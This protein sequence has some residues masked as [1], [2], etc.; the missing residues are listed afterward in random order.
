MQV[1]PNIIY[2]LLR[3]F[4]SFVLLA[5]VLFLGSCQ[6]KEP[7][8]EGLRPE[9]YCA[10]D[11]AKMDANNN[12]GFNM[13]P[14]W[15]N[16]EIALGGF[17]TEKESYSGTHSVMLT[18]DKPYGLSVEF[19]EIQ[20][21]ERLRISVWRKG[22]PNKSALVIQGD[23]K[24]SLYVAHKESS[25]KKEKG[26]EKMEYDVQV[27]PNVN[28]FKIYVWNI[29]D[30]TVY[31]DDLRVRGI[32]DVVY[33]AYGSEQKL[34]LYF[35]DSK[36]EKFE[37]K[38]FAAFESGIHFSDGEWM[39]GIMS[40]ENNVMPV[41]ARLKGDWLDHLIGKKW[42]FRTKMR[43]DFTFKRMRVFSLQNPVT[44]Y[45][46]HEYFAHQLFNQEDVLT[47]RYGFTPLYVN[48]ASLG[49]YAYEEH[50]AKQLIEYNLR[51]EGPILKI[52]EN[53]F[54]RERQ[55]E[56]ANKKT[57]TFP[58]YQAAKVDAFGL[59][60]ILAKPNLKSQFEIAHSLV[61]QYKNLSAPVEE[62]F[63]IDVLAKYWA[64]VDLTNGRHG[65]AWHNQRLYYNP[66]ICKLEPINFDNFTDYYDENSNPIISAFEMNRSGSAE[67]LM[68]KQVFKSK[69]FL[70][71]YLYYLEQYTDPLF[72]QG[73]IDSQMEDVK[74]FEKLI[75]E[76][77]SS[78]QFNPE[79][80][81]HNAEV[82]RPQLSK[83]RDNIAAGIYQKSPLNLEDLNGDT[84]YLPR[85]IPFFVNAYYSE[86]KIGLAS[87]KVENFYGKEIEILGL[88]DETYKMLYLFESP[89]NVSAYQGNVKDTTI[90]YRYTS[91]ARQLAYRVLGH[92]EIL[93][94]ELSLF[95]KNTNLSPYQEL[96]R[97]FNIENC[98]LF[99]HRGD[100]L[101]VSGVHELT[102]KVL[103]PKGKIV[104]FEAGTQVNILNEGTIISHSPIY[105]LGTA[106]QAIK[107]YSSDTT[108]NAFTVLQADQRSVLN[109]VVFEDLNTLEYDGWNLTG[110]VNFYESD[111][112]ISNC[113]F[114][115]NHCEDALNI[116]RS[117]FH[118]TQSKFEDIYADAFDSDFCTGLLD[119]SSFDR[120]GNDAIDFSTSQIHIENCEIFNIQDKGISG[121]EGSTLWVKNTNIVNC[122]IGAASKDLSHVSLE[123]VN[124]ENC[125][126][127]L[128]AL[129][130]KPEY[131]A[132]VLE[133]KKLKLVDCRIK[134]LIEKNSVL[135][136]NGRKIDGVREKVAD[137]F[138]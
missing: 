121:G 13:E 113:S 122:N 125:Y 6:P 64:L 49:I 62:L 98:D 53:P 87:I 35:T 117:D 124:I 16:Q 120:I 81:L 1:N 91:T 135:N 74:R 46:I 8:V 58:Y 23:N 133:S 86:E 33:P 88:A 54:W 11:T 82:I 50:F 137:L 127:G 71:K 65:L 4:C 10:I 115:K 131:G 9:I 102:S 118:V 107:I 106:E 72:L 68:L 83:L 2:Y 97:S 92:E 38:R 105:M 94:S 104:V 126:Y 52:D 36:M 73:F 63:N 114:L 103:V 70:D 130:K 24:N 67:F 5:I 12:F 28:S 69:V 42:S 51:R 37:K 134:Y 136:Y 18:K 43:D 19:K 20:V 90:D 31:F 55:Q 132:A 128:V 27:P 77:F 84:T 76:E 111:V 26:W 85:I 17:L 25:G 34:H 96:L 3:S 57:Y 60:K 75:K 39:K 7:V 47:T 22:K 56:M 61:Y 21:D 116:V 30:D 29:S 41:K 119:Y 89:F 112:D 15:G 80:I 109:H 45:Y 101:I 110:S 79:F 95:R 66:V 78:Y 44:R 108:A 99:E 14:I 40:D 100:S 59:S 129:R 48:G 138:Y 32:P 123:N 93:F